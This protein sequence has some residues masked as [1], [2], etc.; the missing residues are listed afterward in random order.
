MPNMTRDENADYRDSRIAEYEL[1]VRD[2]RKDVATYL[3]KLLKE[4]HGY[5]VAESKQSEPEPERP[6]PEPP[7]ERAVPEAA[8]TPEK[9]EEQPV[10]RGP[11]RPRKNPPSE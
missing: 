9:T 2:G 4:L 11:G 7:V 8:E 10:K 6:E 1:A 5:D 3:A